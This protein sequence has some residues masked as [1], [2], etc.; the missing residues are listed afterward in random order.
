M[1][2]PVPVVVM[3]GAPSMNGI[4]SKSS[5]DGRDSGR[6]IGE[7]TEDEVELEGDV[8]RI[9]RLLMT[10]VVVVL[11]FVLGLVLVVV[12]RL[13][14]LLLLLE[15]LLLVNRER[16]AESFESTLALFGGGGLCVLIKTRF[17]CAD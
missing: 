7:G 15:V 10:L 6:T 14:L 1:P 4:K 9:L 12:L 11:V 3:P 8:E 17:P 2:V 13:L 16:K 5:K